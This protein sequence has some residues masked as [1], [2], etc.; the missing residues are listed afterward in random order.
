MRL[1]RVVV[2]GL[3][4]GFIAFGTVWCLRP[5]RSGE[6]QVTVKPLGR[7]SDK[8]GISHFMVAITNNT[9]FTRECV[10]GRTEVFEFGQ[11]YTTNFMPAVLYRIGPRSGQQLEVQPPTNAGP[12]FVGMCQRR[13][14]GP[15]EV[16]AR[17][18]AVRLKL[19]KPAVAYPN[20]G[21]TERIRVEE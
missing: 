14:M 12:W 2:T 21:P 20:W 4:I 10:V 18:W 1:R 8:A 5:Q 17:V 9:S 15:A 7:V 3:G 19:V 11:G 13:H 16:E 6:P